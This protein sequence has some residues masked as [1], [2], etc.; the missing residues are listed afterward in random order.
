LTRRKLAGDD[1]EKEIKTNLSLLALKI[2][3]TVWILSKLTQ[4]EIEKKR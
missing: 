3:K 2:Q 4:L 1:R